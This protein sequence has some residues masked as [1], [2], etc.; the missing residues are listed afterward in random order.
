MKVSIITPIYNEPRIVRALESIRRQ[1]HNYGIE[2]IVV[3]AGSTDSTLAILESYMGRINNFINEPD[4]GVYDGMNK[5]IKCASGDVISILNADDCYADKD[6]L[7]EVGDVFLK[8]PE[9]GICYGNIL[10]L[11]DCGR[12]GRYWKSNVH[13]RSKWY[14]GW[15]PP[16]PSFFVRKCVYEEF[17]YFSLDFPIAS[18]YE[19]QLR[20]LFKHRV[21]SFYLDKTLVYMAPG[22]KSNGSI[23]I[24]IQA[25]CEAG[26]AWK[27]NQLRGGKMVPILKPLRHISQIFR[28]PPEQSLRWAKYWPIAQKAN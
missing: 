17:G 8:N 10:Y 21:P 9:I 4:R 23:R 19:L 3:G 26:Y 15:R 7:S 25:N 13:R 11:N 1:R 14:W 27:H 22:G 5:G 16:H 28:R 20:F 12:S 6:V 18:D 2:S 24:R